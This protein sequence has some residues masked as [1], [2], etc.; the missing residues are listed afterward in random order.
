M[1]K[2]QPTTTCAFTGTRKGMTVQQKRVL[3][4]LL[5]KNNVTLMH[6]GS[7]RGSDEEAASIA[8]QLD[9]DVV[10]HP[11]V[12]VLPKDKATIVAYEHYTP[13]PALVRNRIMVNAA[14]VVFATPE[15]IVQKFRGSGTWAAIRYARNCGKHLFVIWPDGS[16]QEEN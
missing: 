2:T 5:K 1:N 4:K 12:D 6:N 10:A 16:V 14:Q 13:K 11:A 8:H 15:S 3:T 9:I 7:A